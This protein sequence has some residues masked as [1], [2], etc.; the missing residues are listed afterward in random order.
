M[1]NKEWTELT[2]INQRQYETSRYLSTTICAVVYSTRSSQMEN[3]GYL[4]KQTIY[5]L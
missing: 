3:S 5:P 2:D 1:N 4:C